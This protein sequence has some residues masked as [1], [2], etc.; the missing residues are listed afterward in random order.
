MAHD[1]TWLHTNRIILYRPS[2]TLIGDD[3]RG[4]SVQIQKMIHQGAAP[5]HVIVSLVKVTHIKLGFDEIRQIINENDETTKPLTGWTVIVRHNSLSQFFASMAV[6]MFN[7]D[8][9]FVDSLDE[10]LRFLKER[11]VSLAD[12]TADLAITTDAT[13]T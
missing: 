11:D 8:F 5:V 2:G 6:Q 9:A 12:T 4:V 10:A 3:V 1:T 7:V 13:N